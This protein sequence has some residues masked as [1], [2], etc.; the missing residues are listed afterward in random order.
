MTGN[1]GRAL[2]VRRG[3]AGPASLLFFYLF[4]MIGAYIMGQAVGDA[5]FLSVFP[6]HLPYAMIGS[7]VVSGDIRRDP[8]KFCATLRGQSEEA[9]VARKARTREPA[10]AK[11]LYLS[12]AS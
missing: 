9:I 1:L 7:A 5:L 12:Q 2:G 8:P 11:G 6:K 10:G 3:E 4:L